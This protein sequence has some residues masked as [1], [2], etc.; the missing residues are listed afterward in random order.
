MFAHLS[1]QYRRSCFEFLNETCWFTVHFRCH[2]VQFIFERLILLR[3][4]NLF[5]PPPSKGLN[6][7]EG[8]CKL[9]YE[10]KF[11]SEILCKLICSF[12]IFFTL[13]PWVIIHAA[14]F[15]RISIQFTVIENYSFGVF[16]L[17]VFTGVSRKI[18]T[19]VS[20]ALKLPVINSPYCTILT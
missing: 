20:I 5:P 9:Y 14:F 15:E 3:L 18:F 2:L 10:T 11:L 17:S 6:A 12:A 1:K 16:C 19:Y 7:A 13:P 4:P 8:V